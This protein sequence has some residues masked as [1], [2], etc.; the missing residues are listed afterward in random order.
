MYDSRLP[1]LSHHYLPAYCIKQF[2]HLVH[3]EIGKYNKGY[4]LDEE[5]DEEKEE[6]V[7]EDISA[8]FKEEDAK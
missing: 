7:D 8:L 2:S 1:L 4:E 3:P 6:S 5:E